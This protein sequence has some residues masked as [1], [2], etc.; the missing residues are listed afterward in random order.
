MQQTPTDT[1]RV[2]IVI[3]NS[4]HAIDFVVLIPSVSAAETKSSAPSVPFNN[5]CYPGDR[6]DDCLAYEAAA[7]KKSKKIKKPDKFFVFTSNESNN[8]QLKKVQEKVQKEKE[9]EKFR[10]TK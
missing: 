5:S 2:T 9:K 10:M 4:E 7:S 3:L 1:L 6:D 8:S